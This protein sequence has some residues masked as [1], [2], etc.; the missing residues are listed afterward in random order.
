MIKNRNKKIDR[1][2]FENIR[3]NKDSESV[4]VSTKD[5]F[6]TINDFEIS[7][8]VDITKNIVI[9]SPNKFKSH[10]LDEKYIANVFEN[11]T[12]FIEESSKIAIMNFSHN[13]LSKI[14][15]TNNLEVMENRSVNKTGKLDL[16]QIIIIDEELNMKELMELYKIAIETKVKYFEYQKFP[17]QFQELLNNNEFLAIACPLKEGENLEKFKVP[18]VSEIINRKKG[19]KKELDKNK[20]SSL[21]NELVKNI[22]RSCKDFLDNMEVDF[23]ILDY[24]LAEGIT[25][26]DLVDAGMELIVGV[27]KNE[28]L[29]NKL[30]NQLLKSLEDINVIALIMSA[31]R[32]EDDFQVNRI[33]EI[34]VS[35]DPAYLYTD[36]VMGMAIANQIA[37]T[38]A[39]FN[40]KRY[41][42]EKPGILSSLGPMNDDIFAGLIAGCMSKIFEEE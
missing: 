15:V 26:D 18:N 29:R 11:E 12:F 35:D 2:L 38:K 24:I 19:N 34:D 39:I 23:G 33:R 32:C 8:G 36:E 7:N 25:V 42:E 14:N 6:L 22:I 37:G 31:I 16:G 30:K 5:Y 1:N 28:K 3:L 41:D 21:T 40:F 20:F 4:Y 27:E 17:E 9:L 13:T 10:E